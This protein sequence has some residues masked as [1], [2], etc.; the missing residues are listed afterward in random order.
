MVLPLDEE[1]SLA[2]AFSSLKH[3]FYQVEPTRRAA[4]CRGQSERNIVVFCCLQT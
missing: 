2:K 1:F 4:Y 3:P